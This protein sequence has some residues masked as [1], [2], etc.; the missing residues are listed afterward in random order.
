MYMAKKT[1]NIILSIVCALF[2]AIGSLM[3]S[4]REG[5]DSKEAIQKATKTYG[6]F[7]EGVTF[8]D[9]RKVD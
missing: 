1:K 9:P 4:L 3:K 2:V 8:I 7:N 5:M 6:R